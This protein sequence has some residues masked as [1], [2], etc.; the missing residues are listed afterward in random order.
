MNAQPCG[1]LPLGPS[2]GEAQSASVVRAVD[3][4]A[5]LLFQ[6]ARPV[7]RRGS[8]AKK[9][10]PRRRKGSIHKVI[11]FLPIFAGVSPVR[12]QLMPLPASAPQGGQRTPRPTRRNHV[13]LRRIS[14][15]T[16]PGRASAHR[17]NRRKKSDLALT[18]I[19]SL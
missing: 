8:N 2:G 12:D 4:L 3:C 16:I 6:I 14:L 15:V 5:D 18:P 19:T 10:E 7:A 17:S 1:S 13:G 11:P 9:F